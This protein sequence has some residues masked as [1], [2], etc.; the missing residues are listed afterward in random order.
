MEESIFIDEELQGFDSDE[1]EPLRPSTTSP[2]LIP[3]S[4]LDAEAPR[5]TTSSTTAVEASQV[6]GELS[7]SRVLPLMFRMHIHL[8]RS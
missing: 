4:K 3:A 8:N 7:P 2:K 1:N 5:A 6:E